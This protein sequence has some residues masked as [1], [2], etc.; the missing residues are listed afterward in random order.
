[1]GGDLPFVTSHLL[2]K[3]M[4]QWVVYDIVLPTFFLA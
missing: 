2:P 1:M 3:T 4:D